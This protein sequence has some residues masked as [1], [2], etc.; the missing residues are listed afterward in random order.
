MD[1]CYWS[2]FVVNVV[3]FYCLLE[4]KVFLFG[5]LVDGWVVDNVIKYDVGGYG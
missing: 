5:I 4:W 3:L 2:V 1:V